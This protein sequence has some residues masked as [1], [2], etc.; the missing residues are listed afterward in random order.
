MEL[1]RLHLERK[2]AMTDRPRGQS[3]ALVMKTVGG[4]GAANVMAHAART[5]RGASRRVNELRARHRRPRLAPAGPKADPAADR[6][7]PGN[8]PPSEASATGQA[9][10]A[11]YCAATASGSAR[12]TMS[13]MMV[14]SSKSLGV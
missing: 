3:V 7:L 8:P 2:H 14:L 11:P 6:P 12:V 1:G 4:T 5:R 10:G 13:A 9:K